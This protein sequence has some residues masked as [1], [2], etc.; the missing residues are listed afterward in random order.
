LAIEQVRI[1]IEDSKK[2]MKIDGHPFPVGFVNMVEFG[3]GKVKVF[4]S[5]RAIESGS[6]D[7]DVQVSAD[8]IGKKNYQAYNNSRYERGQSSRTS[9]SHH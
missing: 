2:P 3:N 7:P 5:E 1:K 8:E 6:V 4:T 9:A